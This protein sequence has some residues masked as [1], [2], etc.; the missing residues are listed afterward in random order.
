MGS[1][2]NSSP[3]PRKVGAEASQGTP[4]GG[5][6]L[7]EDDLGR[8]RRAQ[9][10]LQHAHVRGPVAQAS[11]DAQLDG[12]AGVRELR[13]LPCYDRVQAVQR[14]LLRRVLVLHSLRRQAQEA[15]V[16]SSVS[17]FCLFFFL[18][19]PFRVAALRQRGWELLLLLLLPLPLGRELNWSDKQVLLVWCIMV[20]DFLLLLLFHFFP[21]Q[22]R[23][24]QQAHRL[25]RRRIPVQVADGG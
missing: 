24:L 11:G 1:G 20:G 5:G 14:V 21:V 13:V 6:E 10:L 9:H 16:P 8:D 23:L 3:V 2:Y 4:K 17:C 18:S 22:I 12:S 19:F 25:W 7:L 15:Q